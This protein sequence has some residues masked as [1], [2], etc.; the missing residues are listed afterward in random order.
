M[1]PYAEIAV[2][3]GY[4]LEL[5][6]PSTP[7]RYNESLLTHKNV[8]D[9]P[10]KQIENMLVRF[11][12]NLTGRSLLAKLKLKYPAGNRPPQPAVPPPPQMKQKKKP[13]APPVMP[14]ETKP[15]KRRKKSKSTIQQLQALQ[16]PVQSAQGVSLMDSLA[17]FLAR[18]VLEEGQILDPEVANSRLSNGVTV[19]NTVLPKKQE[20]SELTNSSG[21]VKPRTS[22]DS[23]S[24]EGSIVNA[25]GL[26]DMGSQ[27]DNG[28][29]SDD[30]SNDDESGAEV[31]GEEVERIE[32]DND[33]EIEIGGLGEWQ[34]SD[35]DWMYQSSDDRMDEEINGTDNLEPDA[36]GMQCWEYILI[37]D[38]SEWIYQKHHPEAQD[39]PETT[40]EQVEDLLINLS[41]D[42][43]DVA[44]SNVYSLVNVEES[45]RGNTSTENF[46]IDIFSTVED[47]LE[48]GVQELLSPVSAPTVTQSSARQTDSDASFPSHPFSL[49]EFDQWLCRLPVEPETNL[50]QAP[51][52]EKSKAASDIVELTR[53]ERVRT[54]VVGAPG[55]GHVDLKT[56]EFSPHAMANSP[57]LAS[58]NEEKLVLDAKQESGFRPEST[59]STLPAE[60]PEA[61]HPIL[62]DTTPKRV[63][64]PD[65]QHPCPRTADGD[66]KEDEC[67]SNV[68]SEEAS[69]NDV[70]EVP[71]RENRTGTK[72][73]PNSSSR[74]ATPTY[75]LLTRVAKCNKEETWD[76]DN[77]RNNSEEQ[78]Q[79]KPD[80]C[81]FMEQRV[82]RKV[83]G[84]KLNQ[85]SDVEAP[86][87]ETVPPEVKAWET[88]PEPAVSWEKEDVRQGERKP[89][90]GPQPQ[91]SI[92]ASEEVSQVERGWSGTSF[93]SFKMP[94][95]ITP[96]DF[97]Q[98]SRKSSLTEEVQKIS[99]PNGGGKDSDAGDG[100]ASRTVTD[101]STNTHY[102]D[103]ILISQLNR[104]RGAPE[105]VEGVR[106]VTGHN[107][108]IS[109]GLV[110]LKHIDRPVPVKL[111][112]DKSS[113]A[114]LED[115]AAM[116]MS[117]QEGNAD[118]DHNFAKLVTLFPNA[119]QDALKEIF[120]KCHGDLNWTV[121]LLLESKPEQLES[122]SPQQDMEGSVLQEESL[123]AELLGPPPRAEEEQQCILGASKSWRKE[124]GSKTRLSE[125]A[126]HLEDTLS[127]ASYSEDTPR[128]RKLR[129][130]ELLDMG[131]VTTKPWQS[132]P[133]SSRVEEESALGA[134][135]CS[136]T[137]TPSPQPGDPLD[138]QGNGLDDGD[139]IPFE[140]D[141]G[142]AA[143]LHQMFGNPLLSFLE[144]M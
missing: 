69:S 85:S 82:L 99:F 122:L 135:G 95:R 130:G 88:V 66:S 41:A 39:D 97:L 67:R 24:S 28:S 5:L 59:N 65:T 106:I 27:I 51:F 30:D 94:M 23:M 116:L 63:P 68:R 60:D 78:A 84:R 120:E 19:G 21:A 2:G 49:D 117:S 107:C 125:R 54:E 1:K 56:V 104:S 126:P 101:T 87:T 37:K 138:V 58:S 129:H 108:N 17:L 64:S 12:K 62:E 3:N 113:M 13:Q 121:D 137:R 115:A 92:F 32:D 38:N 20:V 73:F 98:T 25:C 119:P 47:S 112:L 10:R 45:A 86:I 127:D 133:N 53:E 15:K 144:G 100:A 91:R 140:L 114:T 14:P 118:K 55:A 44:D 7:W 11:E 80:V 48:S 110:P 81:G 79:A 40:T 31:E 36:G 74:K 136:R 111:T 35:N 72:D 103:F 105:P 132:P 131:E 18:K 57:V 96:D 42:C 76:Q 26:V 34:V 93:A 77:S 61:C 124:D 89:L 71:T 43:T 50:P 29:S 22:G 46:L 123:P 83:A 102:K 8:H 139:M 9:V 70:E 52:S 109:E 4:M 128:M 33:S 6:E 75:D 90:Q 141:P 134:I 143:Q 16:Q 142:F